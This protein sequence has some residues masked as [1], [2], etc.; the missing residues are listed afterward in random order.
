M[1][2]AV[3]WCSIGII[4][5]C[6]LG[7]LIRDRS[8][9]ENAVKKRTWVGWIYCAAAI[10]LIIWKTYV[11][12]SE[13]LQIGTYEYWKEVRALSLMALMWPLAW[14]DLETYRIPNPFIV[15]GLIVR[16][17]FFLCE[18]NALG[19]PAWFGLLTDMI[20]V[21]V[22]LLA[23][24]LCNLLIKKS[25]GFGDMKLFAVMGL[26][27]GLDRIWEAIFYSLIISFFVA[28]FLLVTK[29]K[30]RKDT[31]PFGPALVVGTFVS[32]LIYRM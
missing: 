13:G 30:T 23:A 11:S 27:L 10:G 25:V 9:H 4:C 29:K 21:T 24:V 18:L 16:V 12:S 31:I 1:E 22:L 28:L 26:L 6:S 20:A 3:L 5:C 17:F 7:L 2:M 14:I 15:M 19:R 32:V 8:E